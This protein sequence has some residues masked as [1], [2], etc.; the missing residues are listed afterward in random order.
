M[1][2]GVSLI[3]FSKASISDFI[4]L[5]QSPLDSKL[6]RVSNNDKRSGNLFNLTYATKS[7]TNGVNNFGSKYL[8][9]I[10]ASNN[11]N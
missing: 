7:F 8:A 5:G 9:L 1:Y 4:V 11:F 6:R 10:N 2:F 3:L